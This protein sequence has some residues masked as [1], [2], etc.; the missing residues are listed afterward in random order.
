MNDW[1]VDP[2]RVSGDARLDGHAGTVGLS[3]AEDVFVHGDAV[4]GELVVD[5]AEY[6]YTDVPAARSGQPDDRTVETAVAG[7]ED[8]YVQRVDGDLVV[9]GAADVFVADAGAATLSAP[10]AE[11]VFHDDEAAPTKPPDDYEVRVAGWRQTETARDPRDGVAVVGARNEVTVEQAAHDLTV[12]VVGW[13]NEV[14]VEGTDAD[15]TVFFVGRDNRVSVGPYL[16]ATTAAD[17]GTDNELHRE[18]IPPEALIETA[19]SEAKS[20]LLFGRHRLTW[21]APTD[22][23]WCPN[24]GADADT[25]IVRRQSDAFY[26]FGV[27]VWTFDEGGAAYECEEC[28]T[29]VGRVSLSESERR[30]ALR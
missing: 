6:V 2:K 4:T 25:V 8:G 3:V 5:D 22:E 12:Y 29:V 17:G 23:E 7:E 26:L 10:G 1:T 20:G 15:V 27:P 28:T 13:G 11:R 19:E 24:C 14:T 16:E 21:Q 30:A 9:R 18:P